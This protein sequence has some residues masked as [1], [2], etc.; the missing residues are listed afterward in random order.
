M[1][2]EVAAQWLR[3]RVLERTLEA[4]DIV[5]LVLGAEDGEQLPPFEAGAHI[6]IS[7]PNGLKR[8][9]SL[10]NPPHGAQHYEIAVL[11][12]REGRGGSRSVHED[13]QAGQRVDISAPRNLFPLAAEG[14]VLLLAGGIGI[15]PLLAMAETLHAESRDFQLHICSRS[16]SRAAFRGRLGTAPYADRV[17]WHFDDGADEQR[18]ALA[19]LLANSSADTHLHVCGP[20]GFMDHVLGS[21]RAAGWPEARLHFEYFSVAPTATDGDTAFEIVIK[22][23]GQTIKVPADVSAATALTEAGVAVALSCEQGICGSCLMNVLEGEPEHRDFFLSDDE[24]A[25]NDQ[26]TPCCSRARSAR[27]VL[28]L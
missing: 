19:E 10:C 17:D 15:T 14:P 26:F 8:Q 28:D 21:A 12:E 22:S 16:A 13:L 11:H 2:T 7:L 18:L 5:R 24:R 4:E 25:A 23:S 9:Y 27:L 3:T 1:T 6:E 20:Q